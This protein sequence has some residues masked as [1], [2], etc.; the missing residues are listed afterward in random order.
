ME[1][2]KSFTIGA[3]IASSTL[4]LGMNKLTNKVE[5]YE[6]EESK[7]TCIPVK[8]NKSTFKNKDK[9][10]TKVS[11]VETKKS[12]K[13]EDNVISVSDVSF[14]LHYKTRET[15]KI[16]MAKYG[17]NPNFSFLVKVAEVEWHKKGSSYK[18]F[19][20]MVYISP[21]IARQIVDNPEINKIVLKENQQKHSRRNTF[22]VK[23]SYVAIE[24]LEPETRVVKNTIRNNKK[25]TA[26]VNTK[27]STKNPEKQHSFKGVVAKDADILDI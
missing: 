24:N 21:E 17:R 10:E 12:D 18:N 22:K 25:S 19:D 1:H 4:T 23:G 5:K 11:K 16:Q 6:N 7:C 26:V 14:E 8:K 2:I 13:F 9:K 15:L 20:S 27:P 3:I